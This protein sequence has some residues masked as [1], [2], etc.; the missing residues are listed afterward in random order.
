MLIPKRFIVRH[1]IL[2]FLLEK[3]EN[4]PNHDITK[5]TTPHTE[6]ALAENISPKDII[7]YHEVLIDRKHITCDEVTSNRKLHKITLTLDGRTA[8]LEETYLSEGIEA[9]NKN[10]DFWFKVSIPVLALF[11]SATS[12]INACRTSKNQNLNNQEIEHLKS[13][14]N[15]LES[16]SILQTQPLLKPN[17]DTLKKK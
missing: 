7:K 14:L 13:R 6:I 8:A 10:I 5:T 4:D 16:S 9:R 1:K 17:L 2:N 12:T 3:Q 15:K 11:L